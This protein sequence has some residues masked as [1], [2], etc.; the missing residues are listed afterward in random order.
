VLLDGE[1]HRI[2]DKSF[3]FG[4]PDRYNRYYSVPIYAKSDISVG[5]NTGD[6][7]P[8]LLVDGSRQEP[9]AS[10]TGHAVFRLTLP[11]SDIRLV[12]GAARPSDILPVTDSRHLGIMV[13][14]LCWRQDGAEVV[15]PVNSPALIDGFHTLEHDSSRGMAEP[16]RWT[17]GNA[18][19]PADLVPP[20]R[21]EVVLELRYTTWEGSALEP[22][23][24]PETAIMAA[25]E[26]LGQNCDLAIAQRHYGVEMPL[27]L[28][29]WA[30]TRHDRLLAG[31][32]NGFKG[33]GD[34]ALTVAKWDKGDYRLCTPYLTF[35]TFDNQP[36]DDDSRQQML[37]LGC[38]TLRLLRRKLL[39]DIAAARRIFVFQTTDSAFGPADMHRLHAAIRGIGPAALLCVT[40]RRP[41]QP[42]PGV[43][44]LDDGLYAGTL[45]RLVIPDGAQPRAMEGWLALCADTLALHRTPMPARRLA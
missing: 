12:S 22:L 26:N 27:T 15:V 17:N 14:A 7:K 35:H 39:H 45:A 29:R 18:G 36:H 3:Q 30:G 1:S 33:L 40:P 31:L 16:F 44:R 38:S 32:R 20:W 19:L 6:M 11:A 42:D 4:Q 34:P 43:T 10:H 8:F 25:F 13:R 23:A 41:E 21:G 24:R 37:A 5:M 2:Q 28:L 9:D